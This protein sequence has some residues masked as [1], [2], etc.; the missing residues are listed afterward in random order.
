MQTLDELIA[1]AP[2]FAGLRP[3]F[4]QTIAACGANEHFD[5][6]A[7]L[8][9]EGDPA[10]R[11]YLLRSGSVALEL[12]APAGGP[13]LIET[14]H[15]G[16]VIGFSWLFAPYRWGF[17][18]RARELTRAVGFDGACLRGKCDEDHELGYQL[19]SRFA[20]SLTDNLEA[21]RLQ[22]LDVYGHARLD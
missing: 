21:T 14:L 9:R 1:A 15:A 4:L 5:A 11:F 10:E 12:N 3:E 7:L 18:A 6:G 20:L 8:F 16:E 22:L 17:D 13:L 19:M 2:L